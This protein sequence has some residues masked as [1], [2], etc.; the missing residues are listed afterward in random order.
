MRGSRRGGWRRVADGIAAWA[1]LWRARLAPT[2]G[3]AAVSLVLLVL[4]GWAAARFLDWA[5]LV[6]LRTGG[7]T[8]AACAAGDGPGACWA[9]IGA[10]WRLILFGLYP[11]ASVWRAAA[12]SGLLL[13]LVGV[14][15]WARPGLRVLAGLWPAT[16]AASVLLLRGGV[17]GLAPVAEQRWGGVPLTLLLTTAGLAGAFPLAVAVAL[18]RHFA[19]LPVVRWLAVAYVEVIRGVPLISLLFMASVMLPLFLP[20]GVDFDKLLRA[21]I[22][23]IL[24]AAAYLAEVVRAGLRGVPA[25]QAEAADALGLTPWQKT[26]LVIL[27]QAL[28]LVIPPLLNTAIGFFK[29]TSLVLIIGLYDLLNAGRLAFQ[30]PAWQGAWREVYLFVGAVYFVVCLAASRTAAAIERRGPGE[31]VAGGA[32]GGGE[33]A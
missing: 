12:A 10:Q 20:A 31:A 9:V 5:V 7:G 15:A 8:P 11:A 26:R 2:P 18:A 6:P 16:L 32:V 28:R 14:T 19:R 22:A 13:A 30:A 4:L 24:F 29:D 33:P 21:Q 27:P 25:G 1:R 3:Q 23:F 17:L